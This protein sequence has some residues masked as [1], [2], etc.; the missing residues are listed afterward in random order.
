MN[1]RCSD[2]GQWPESILSN[3]NAGRPLICSLHTLKASMQ[4]QPLTPNSETV[5][6]FRHSSLKTISCSAPRT[7]AGPIRECSPPFPPRKSVTSTPLAKCKSHY[8]N[9]DLRKN[10]DDLYSRQLHDKKTRESFWWIIAKP[11]LSGH[12]RDLPKCPY[13]GGCRAMFVND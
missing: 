11:L 4:K 1:F 5:H 2:L 3:S 7:C 10:T 9:D 8:E 12:L 13:N 6:C